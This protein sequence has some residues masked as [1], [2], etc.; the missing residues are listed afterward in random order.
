MKNT[1]QNHKIP[2][3]IHTEVNL[4]AYM[5]FLTTGR[6]MITPKETSLFTKRSE[7]SLERD[8]ASALGI[9]HTKLGRGNGSDRVL[10]N[11]Y[12]IA[13]YIVSKKSKVIS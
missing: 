3:L 4:L 1:K 11:V 6:L 10:Y 7:I 8:R 2:D 12:D 9:P 13:K 5:L